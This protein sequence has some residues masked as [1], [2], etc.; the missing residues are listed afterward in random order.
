MQEM[1]IS[2]RTLKHAELEN[3]DKAKAKANELDYHPWI[4]WM[5]ANFSY[6][7]SVR[8]CTFLGIK[9]PCHGFYLKIKNYKEA[10]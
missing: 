6:S 3:L 2:S 5:R 4:Q 7:A 9:M 1:S 10:V 8:M